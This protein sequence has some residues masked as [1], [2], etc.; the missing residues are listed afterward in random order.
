MTAIQPEAPDYLAKLA[1]EAAEKEKTTLDQIVALALSAQI[2]DWK[3]RD[4]LERRAVRGRPEDVRDVLA[5]VPDVAPLPGD[6]FEPRPHLVILGCARGAGANCFHLL[7]PRA[8][9]ITQGS[10][11]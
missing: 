6:D 11:I 5:E 8:R 10:Q 4:D 2:S 1:S 7:A 9:R 3:V